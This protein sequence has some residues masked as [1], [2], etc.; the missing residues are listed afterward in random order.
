MKLWNVIKFFIIAVIINFWGNQVVHDGQKNFTR[1]LLTNFIHVILLYFILFFFFWSSCQATFVHCL[2]LISVLQWEHHNG[3]SKLA[4][5]F[6][7]Y[8]VRWCTLVVAKLLF[9]CFID[10][11]EK[12]RCAYMIFNCIFALICNYH[13]SNETIIINE[14]H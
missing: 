9:V 6:T 2:L 5:L 10:F 3:F 14:I 12:A 7:I 8:T 1:K 11:I 4:D 13:R